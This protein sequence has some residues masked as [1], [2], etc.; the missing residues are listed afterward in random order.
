MPRLS[1][2]VLTL[3][4]SFTPLGLPA[5]VIAVENFEEL[6]PGELHESFSGT[7]FST[8][9]PWQAQMDITEVVNPAVSFE[10]G[11][12][13][14]LRLTG[15]NNNAVARDLGVN[16]TE[17]F[18]VSYQIRHES[19]D[20]NSNLFSALWLGEGV[21][22]GA[23][24]FGVKV[25][26]GPT[27]GNREDFMGRI[28]GRQEAYGPSQLMTS[29]TSTVHDYLLV[30]RVSKEEGSASYNRL[31]FWVNPSPSDA[32]TPQGISTGSINVESIDRIGF[33][34]V[35]F[36]DDSFLIDNLRIGTTFADVVIP[37]PTTMLL[38]P[39][40]MAPFF[41]RQRA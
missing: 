1:P 21:Y 32:S 27:A 14:A 25:N 34:T 29:T 38:L 13:R 26:Q 3:P 20:Q 4:L 8:T 36:N 41:S 30:A 35:N 39:L 15:N 11:G 2:L 18:F 23:P 16:L 24:S 28:S 19:G 40:A 22:I 9:Q 31:E 7:G 5:V 33:R 10:N 12:S 37:E 6:A 17:T